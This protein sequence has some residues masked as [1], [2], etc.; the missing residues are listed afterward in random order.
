ML[1]GDMEAGLCG[2]EI[3]FAT[4]K[5]MTAKDRILETS[6]KNFSP[7]VMFARRV[8]FFSLCLLSAAG[9][10]WLCWIAL[11][12]GGHSWVDYL[13]MVMF[14]LVLPWNIIGF[15]NATIGFM[16]SMF[17]DNPLPAV[18]PSAQVDELKPIRQTTAILLCIRNESPA[19]LVR[20]MTPML[21]DL[22]AS[23]WANQF[24]LYA[25]SDTNDA[26]VAEQEESV[27]GELSQKY[28]STLPITY[29]R[30][31]DNAGYKAGN[32]E[33]F[34]TRWGK[35]H[36]Y[37]LVLDADSLMTAGSIM[38]LVRIMESNPQLGILQGLV[39]GMP[40]SSPFTR[41]F[42]FGMRLAMRSYTMGTAWWQGDCGPYWGH[43]A[44]IRLKPFIESCGLP[45]LPD[46]NGQP[47]HILSHDQVEAVLMRKA[48]FDVRVLPI[49]D[50]SYEENPP[51]MIEYMRRDLRWCEGNM[52]YVHLL[53]MKGIKSLSRFQLL[54]AIFMFLGSPAWIGL[55]VVGSVAVS[56]ET[57]PADFIDPTVGSWLF[58]LMIVTCYLP[59]IA[60]G[61]EVLFT[62]DQRKA[63]GGAW[64]FAVSFVIETL[65]SLVVIAISWFNHA[66]FLF[67][68]PFGRRAGWG[69]QARDDHS[70][71]LDTAVRQFLPH[72]LLGVCVLAMLSIFQP[73][74]VFYAAFIAGG[75]A[76]SI[77][78]AV[79]TSLPGVG[80]A[81]I[82]M[83][84]ARIPEELNP[85]EILTNLGLSAL[86]LSGHASASQQDHP[87]Q[88]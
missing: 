13:L 79:L 80:R 77:P 12:P 58:W 83:G 2:A 71:P 59:K 4:S 55:L 15:W 57:T 34:C 44:V 68:L 7:R 23:P 67:G 65:F 53:N 46:R 62:A 20:N 42:Q 18:F 29:R 63:F 50:G 3:Y 84:L 8:M 87:R 35:L 48:G 37:M 72:T 70:I 39:V 41:L 45:L 24:H 51:T 26:S 78:F 6:S 76:I 16:V 54:N 43:N 56:M 74:G 36:E 21:R 17:N 85:P 9:L 75:L 81:M 60:S 52:Q 38:R 5:Y 82:R 28:Q 86:A 25:L 69:A 33:D 19:R 27:F 1:T 14:A 88:D 30:R 40:S 10:L 64:S 31:T 11:A 22:S 47:R 66:V 73:S 61:L 32:I 49:E